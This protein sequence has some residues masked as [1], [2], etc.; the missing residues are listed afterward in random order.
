MMRARIL[1]VD[2]E[3]AVLDSLRDLLRKERTR[4]D[5]AFAASGKEA[6]ELLAA[7]AF[8]I[9][10]TD[11]RM[12]GMDGAQLLTRVKADYPSITRIVLSGHADRDSLNRA[13]SIAHQFLSKPCEGA[14]LRSTIERVHALRLR[15]ESDA[16]KAVV[17]RVDQLPSI[18]RT[19]Q[20]LTMVAG[21]PS[22]GL[23]DVARVIESDTAMSAKV[24]QLVSSS[25][26][27]ARREVRSIQQAISLLGVELLKALAL[28]ANAFAVAAETEAAR[29]SLEK[30][31]Q[32]SIAC[33]RAAKLMAPPALAEE[34]FTAALV[35]DIGKLVL[36]LGA[37]DE[38]SLGV[39][40]AEIGG[41]LLGLWGLPLPI[42]EAVAYHHTPS[43]VVDDRRELVAIV[44]AADALVGQAL[45]SESPSELDEKF[46]ADAGMADRLP[47]WRRI[48]SECVA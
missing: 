3:R 17:G 7:S 35:H 10:V 25:Y 33:A 6:L 26:F 44:H 47:S 2:D 45:A 30:L 9:V 8:D 40:H 41:Y 34:A 5:M 27:G 19:Y 22:K 43:S 46:L 20:A 48:A 13:I 15:V 28:T 18:P 16:V 37:I 4:W 1:F 29:I 23:V 21:D 12:P 31:Q 42:L 11:M 24:L 14:V 39:T 36:V 32:Q 38:D